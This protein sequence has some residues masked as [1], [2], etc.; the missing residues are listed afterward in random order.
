MKN[1]TEHGQT[2]EP[3]QQGDD[4]LRFLLEHAADAFFVMDSTGRIVDVN[5]SACNS[6][7]YTAE[8]L[9]NM[10]VWDLDEHWTPTRFREFWQQIVPGKPFTL[11]AENRRKDGTVFPVEIHTVAHETSGR[12]L[13][14]SLVRDI[15][16]RKQMEQAL[17]TSEE[18]YRDLYDEAPIAYQSVGV[19]GRIRSANRRSAELFGYTMNQL[20]G[21]PVFELMADTPAGKGR[22][23]EL[24]QLF[25]SGQEIHGE[26]L[27]CRRADGA[28]LW[29]SV[30]VRPIMD[31]KGQILASR[32]MSEDI[33][34]RKRLEQALQQYSERLQ[35][36]VDMRTVQLRQSE[37]RQRALLEINNAIISNLDRDSLFE[38]IAK[39]LRPILPFDRLSLCIY[40]PPSD[41]LRGFAG[42]G[43]AA[44]KAILDVGSDVPRQ[45]SLMGRAVDEK[46]PIIA[47][48]L[49]DEQQ[50]SVDAGIIANLIEL[51]MR[52]L[53]AL[54]LMSKGKVVGVLNFTSLTSGQYSE[55]DAEFSQEIAKQVALAVE[56]MQAYEEIAQLKK[57]LEQ[58]KDRLQAENVYLQE[59]MKTQSGFEDILGKSPSLR[60]VLRQVEQVAPTDTTVLVLGETGTGKELIARAIHELSP[61]KGRPLVTV[62]CGAISAGLVESELF[63]HERGAFTGALS[64]KIGRFELADGGTLFLDE[65]GDLPLDLQVKLLRV[66]QE[67]QIERVGGTRT[68][69]IDVRVIGA[70]H[71]DLE[72]RVEEGRFRQDLFYRLNVFPIHMPALRERREDI[73][74]LVRHF[75]LHFAGKLGKK[76]ESIARP[77]MDALESYPWPGNVRELRNVIERS[78][79]VTRGTA[80]ELGDWITGGRPVVA[81]SE[82]RKLADVERAHIVRVL[83]DCGWRVSGRSGAAELLGLKPTTLEARMKKLG[84][85]RP[86]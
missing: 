83:E 74:V 67:G 28:Q 7:G 65:I 76:I 62:N 71:A 24:F 82:A 42:T 53:L 37:E 41:F 35:E 14:L 13:A 56:N 31:A 26:E 15:T 34:E 4:V 63:G 27:E 46:R 11:E 68:I 70:T 19:D 9:L 8:E 20:I 50:T 10:N 69:V 48:D 6:L 1:T 29:I 12:F 43:I 33:T 52:S 51:G 75:V 22:G 86:R 45:G 39:A 61:R 2:K 40:D 84:I 47:R 44:Q 81:T 16:E 78:V 5:Q 25:L 3:F 66:L 85:R 49:R 58:E 55:P 23:Q 54:P 60:K 17:R 59:E 30:S 36:L 77:T 64:R 73:P 32:S 57:R 38:A 80:L 79:I 72:K 21:R 18:R